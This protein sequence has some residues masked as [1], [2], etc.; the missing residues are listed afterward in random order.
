MRLLLASLVLALC[1]GG[2]ASAEQGHK[3]DWLCDPVMSWTVSSG[4]PTQ[5]T[6][7]GE[8]WP[9]CYLGRGGS[10][11]VDLGGRWQDRIFGGAGG[12]TIN[13]GRGYDSAIGNSGHDEIYGEKQIDVLYGGSGNDL[14]DG[15]PGHDSLFGGGFCQ[16]TWYFGFLPHSQPD[17]LRP[18]VACG[19]GGSDTLRGGEGDDW[20]WES[21]SDN[22]GDGL[23]DHLDGGPG[24]D[25]CAVEPGIDTW[26]DC[27]VVR[28]LA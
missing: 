15:G 19:W 3:Y 1:M 17:S 20:L 14:L 12:D 27:E 23:P 6:Y 24:Y 26:T 10:D 28:E 18:T 21:N 4:T 5:D 8:R 7:S 16:E 25:Y 11:T 2:V 22:H 13:L 9:S